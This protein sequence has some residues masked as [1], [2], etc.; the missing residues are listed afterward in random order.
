MVSVCNLCR[1]KHFVCDKS[2]PVRQKFTKAGIACTCIMFNY[3]HFQTVS[4]FI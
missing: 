4:R 1:K 3:K 2:K